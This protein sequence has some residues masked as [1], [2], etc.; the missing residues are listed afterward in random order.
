LN[1][2]ERHIG[3]Y[4]KDT[5][6]LSLLE[7]GAYTRLMDVYYTRESA[8]P[9]AEAMRLIGARTKEERAAVLA[10]LRE[11]FVQ[12]EGGDWIQTRCEREIDRFKDKQRKAKASADARW[13]AHRPQSV[14]N[15]NASADAMRTHC[16]GNAPRARPQTP[17]TS[18]QEKDPPAPRVPPWAPPAWMPV[19]AWTAFVS[20]RKAKGKRAPFTD[21]ARDGIVLALDKLRAAGHDPGAVLQESVVNG[22]SGVFPTKVAGQP[23]QQS[24]R[25]RDD[26][27]A[28]AEVS[29]WTGGILGAEPAADFIDMEAPNA[30]ALAVR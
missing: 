7:H 2:Y 22:W 25:E 13:S 8:I 21:A 17:D 9:E 4:L 24:F 1:Y 16:E 5:S 19:E 12:E 27:Q 30:T 29:R 3:D 26:A 28:R 11:F 14:G 6:H 10:V 20:M 18:N 23:R 15:A